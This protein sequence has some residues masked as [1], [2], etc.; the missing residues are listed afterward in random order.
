MSKNNK[1]N[2]A[3]KKDY[4]KIGIKEILSNTCC[5]FTVLIF[6][7]YLFTTIFLGNATFTTNIG[8][9]AAVF[10]LSF[11]L[12]AATLAFERK[13]LPFWESNLILYF[14]IG[15]V[16]YLIVV[17]LPGKHTDAKATLTAMGI[18][19]AAFALYIVIKL[20][21]RKNKR[22]KDETKTDKDKDKDKNTKYQPKF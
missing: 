22:V 2:T 11:A 21:I 18:Y 12:S 15:A 20:I 17:R 6:A 10:A 7:V 3:K 19:T 8:N 1:R 14:L 16:F 13:K 9:T 5:I 4:R